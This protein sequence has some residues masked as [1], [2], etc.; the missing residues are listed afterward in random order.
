M[1]G[2]LHDFSLAIRLHQRVLLVRRKGGSKLRPASFAVVVLVVLVSVVSPT[3]A[4]VTRNVL[5]RVLE[6]RVGGSTGITGTAFTLDVNGREYLVTAKHMVEKLKHKGVIEISVRSGQWDPINV[7]VYRCEGAVD[8]A[9]LI[10]PR[11]LTVNL[12]LEPATD[13]GP[14]QARDGQDMYF[15]GFPFGASAYSVSSYA[16]RLNGEYPIP[17]IKK[18]LYSGT[19]E[20]KDKPPV[21]LL[22]GYNNHG[23]SGAPIVYKDLDQPNDWVFHV[24]GVVS[25]FVPE[26][27]PVVKPDPIKPREDTSK[28]EAWR[29]QLTDRGKILR[30]TGRFVPLNTGIVQG[31]P[32]KYA[33]DLI[34]Q[35][36]EGPAATDAVK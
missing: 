35:H 22:D 34:S 28:V 8:I 4:Q 33:L 13:G 5:M 19:F 21:I 11:Q 12:P 10:P 2:A 15:A 14:G 9:V 20:E 3:Y 17:I 6:I 36:Q 1:T 7:T 27:A 24:F 32:I 25:G 31:Y 30:D 23:F 29:L 26:L 16:H 18:G